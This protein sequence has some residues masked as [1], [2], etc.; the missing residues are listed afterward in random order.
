MGY[1]KLWLAHHVKATQAATFLRGYDKQACHDA[2]Q[3]RLDEL[4]LP[5]SLNEP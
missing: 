3:A 5:R 4:A 2:Y 1:A